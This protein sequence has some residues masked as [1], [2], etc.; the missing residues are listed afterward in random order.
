MTRLPS[1]T[2]LALVLFA[3]SASIA[4]ADQW[5][6]VD[7]PTVFSGQFNLGI[8]SLPIKSC[9]LT[10]YSENTGLAVAS[11]MCPTDFLR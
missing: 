5:G 11:N 2:S 6:L 10:Q 8:D 7:N 9:L 4:G 3:T 1:F